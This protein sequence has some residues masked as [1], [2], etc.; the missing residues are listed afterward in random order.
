[1]DL[2]ETDDYFKVSISNNYIKKSSFKR[3]QSRKIINLKNYMIMFKKIKM[4]SIGMILLILFSY[5]GK[6]DRK[7]NKLK[8]DYEKI[9][10]DAVA[11]SLIPISPGIPGDKPFWNG[12]SKQFIHVPSF[13]FRNVDGAVKYKFTIVAS[14]NHEYSFISQNPWADLSPVWKQ[15]P[16]GFLALEVQGLDTNGKPVGQF[17]SRKFYKASAF[18]GP[19]NKKVMNY[20]ESAKFALQYL[21]NLGH[22]Q[23][24]K[25]NAAPD[26]TF[27]LYCYPSKIIGAVIGNMVAYSKLSPSDAGTA[28]TIAKNAANYLI[29]ISEPQGAPLEYFPPTYMGEANTSKK[30]KGQVMVI[31]PAEVAAN[32]L[33]LFDV[34]HDSVYFDAALRIAGTYVKLQLPSGTWKL[35]LWQNGEA[36][37]EN[38]CVPVDMLEFFD[39]LSNQYQLDKYKKITTTIFNWI[40]DNPVKTFSWE[41]QFEDV[42]PTEPYKNMTGHGACSFAIYLFNRINE[43]PQYKDIAEELLRF[44][45]DQFVVWEKPMPQEREN[46]QD[47]ITP[48]GLEQYGYYVPIDDS[49][50]KLMMGYLTAY[51]K[52]GKK[53]YWA[54]AVEFANTQTVAQLP[55]TGKY[56]TYWEWGKRQQRDWIDGACYDAKVMMEMDDFT[57]NKN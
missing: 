55:E 4:T 37:T 16:V 24:W 52:T 12:Y 50:I 5:S 20:G 2:F 3:C 18:N 28:L 33:N 6:I 49:G 48:C 51:K 21:Y 57:K 26:T 29:S 47:W 8:I 32:Y 27:D 38:D 13:D 15:V 41:G 14:D 39:R 43:N 17:S 45:E 23:N 40:M 53:L 46:V 35:K 30:Y 22:F 54:K 34:T 19:Y 31:Y 1:M 36:V 9:R 11:E 25:I 42:A 10:E 56:P 44:S 7:S